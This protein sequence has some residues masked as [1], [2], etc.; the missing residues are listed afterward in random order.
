MKATALANS[1][2]AFIKYWG[3]LDERLIL[4]MNS[5]I[6]MTVDSQNTTT[7]VEFSSNLREDEI[8]LNKEI[9]EGKPRDKVVRHLDL[10]RKTAGI[11]DNARVMSE[12]NFPTAAGLASSASGFAALT[13][14]GCA[15]AG[16]ELDKKELSIISRQ[17]SGSSSRSIY[18]GYVEWLRGERSEDSYSVQIA[19]ENH[20]DIRDIAVVI[21]TGERPMSTREAM[22]LSIST[23]PIY[24]T[25]LKVVKGMLDKA[26]KAIQERDFSL[27][28]R[29]AESDA[30]LMHAVMMTTQPPLFYWEPKTLEVIKC[31]LKWR[32]E[33]LECY[34]T[35]DTGANMHIFSLPD[36]VEEI[37]SRLK[38]IGGIQDYFVSKP[39]K[40][41]E[42]INKHLF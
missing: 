30:V 11:T 20:F 35:V 26:R 17:G 40:G 34:F 13:V 7:T 41:T 27:L 28:G 5:N 39:G 37:K 29:T 6:S 24:Q 18:G 25:R 33:G 36:D 21:A 8:T 15:A 38:E 16:L 10:I 2:T 31:V 3:K 32:S 19:D 4:P 9:A 14:A 12:N 23:S 42:L 1:N 22:P